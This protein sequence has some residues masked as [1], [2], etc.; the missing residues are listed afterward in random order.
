VVL[1]VCA[2]YDYHNFAFVDD[3]GEEEKNRLETLST[4]IFHYIVY[5]HLC[6]ARGVLIPGPERFVWLPRM[7]KADPTNTEQ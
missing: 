2:L 1:P 7:E 3:S 6:F 5:K 4:I